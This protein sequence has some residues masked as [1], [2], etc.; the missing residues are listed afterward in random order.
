MRTMIHQNQLRGLSRYRNQVV[1]Q[2]EQDFTAWLEQNVGE[3]DCDWGR[4]YDL[5]LGRP[6]Y[7]TT[8]WFRDPARATL[9][10]LRWS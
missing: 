6:T 1:T 2:Q 9:T 8:W 5:N 4:I 10:L 7:G 3:Q